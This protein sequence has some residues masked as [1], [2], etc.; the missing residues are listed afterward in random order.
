MTLIHTVLIL[1]L[2][3]VLEKM[4]KQIT[5]Y[6]FMNPMMGFKLQAALFNFLGYRNEIQNN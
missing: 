1:M 5:Q 3:V 6:N 4:K 2:V